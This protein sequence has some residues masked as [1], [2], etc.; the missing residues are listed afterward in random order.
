M[1][2]TFRTMFFVLMMVY[3]LLNQLKEPHAGLSVGGP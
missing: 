2:L 3:V 1:P